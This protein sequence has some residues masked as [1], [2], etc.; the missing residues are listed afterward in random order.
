MR[1]SVVRTQAFSELTPPRTLGRAGAGWLQDAQFVV[2]GQCRVPP[3][4]SGSQNSFHLSLFF[5]VVSELL[6]RM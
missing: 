6:G 4:L 1:K 2:K 5:I 3:Y